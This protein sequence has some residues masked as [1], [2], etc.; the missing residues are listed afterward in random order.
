MANSKSF[1]WECYLWLFFVLIVNIHLQQSFEG[2]EWKT[3]THGYCTLNLESNNCP[4]IN[5]KPFL[6][7][8]LSTHYSIY[9]FDRMEVPSQQEY[10]GSVEP[11]F[12]TRWINMFLETNSVCAEY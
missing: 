4:N 10:Q 1:Y 7:Q 8:R 6:R 11:S 12:I 2:A 3:E 5:N 9:T